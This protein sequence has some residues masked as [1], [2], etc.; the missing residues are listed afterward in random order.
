MMATVRMLRAPG[1]A[2]VAQQARRDDERSFERFFVTH[3]ERVVLIAYKVLGD[4]Q[5]AEDVAQ[6]V[7]LSFHGRVDPSA[8]WAAGMALGRVRAPGPEYGPG[9]QEAP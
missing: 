4:R 1:A 8:E 5:S 6:D 9:V 7:F 2:L 3:Y